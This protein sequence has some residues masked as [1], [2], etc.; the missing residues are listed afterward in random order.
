MKKYEIMVILRAGIPA[1]EQKKEMDKL[2]SLLSSK[3]GKVNHL[4]NWNERDFAQPIQK[5]TKGWY[6]VYKVTSSNEILDEFRRV[7]KID[8][9]ILRF[10]IINNQE[11]K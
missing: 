2:Q 3:G 4:D 7:V 11:S 6:L 5:Q 10:L 9:Q 1:E 8:P